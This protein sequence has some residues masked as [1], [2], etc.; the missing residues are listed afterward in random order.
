M[1]FVAGRD[2]DARRE[3]H[4]NNVAAGRELSVSISF[5][6]GMRPVVGGRAFRRTPQDKWRCYAS[7][8]SDGRT[9][10]GGDAIKNSFTQT[11]RRQLVTSGD[12][13]AD[14]HHS[15]I[16]CRQAGR[17]AGPS[18]GARC[19]AELAARICDI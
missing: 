16:I 19:A 8:P 17:P 4:D 3:R 15:I 6:V 14:R 13:P 10:T 5:I 1:K 18:G 9:V 7:A 2:Q 11:V 12:V